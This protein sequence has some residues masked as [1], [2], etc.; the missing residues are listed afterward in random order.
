MKRTY[1]YRIEKGNFTAPL[2]LNAVI[3]QLAFNEQKLIPVI[4]QDANSK[5]V[6]CWPG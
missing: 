3:E 5:D 6:L 2:Q 1:F 4:T